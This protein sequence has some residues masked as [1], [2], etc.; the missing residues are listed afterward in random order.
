MVSAYR[1]LMFSFSDLV[2][3]F[4]RPKLGLKSICSSRVSLLWDWESGF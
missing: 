1:I 2:F 4:I 3:R